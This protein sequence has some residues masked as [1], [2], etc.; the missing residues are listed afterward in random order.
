MLGNRLVV[1]GPFL[2][3]REVE[4]QKLVIIGDDGIEEVRMMRLNEDKEI[5]CKLS[6]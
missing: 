2:N 1:E 4:C 3:M 6:G 5:Q